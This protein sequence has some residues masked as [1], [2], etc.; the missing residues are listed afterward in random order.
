MKN[1]SFLAIAAG[2]LALI[3]CTA[4]VER[5]PGHYSRRPYHHGSQVVI[6]RGHDRDYDRGYHRGYDRYDGPSHRRGYSERRAVVHS[7]P[8]Y[9]QTR[10]VYLNDSRGRYY[11]RSGRRIY[12]NVE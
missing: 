6:D 8:G 4:V 1:L 2:S 9:S 11:V 12:V 7:E 10:V 3:G 5:R